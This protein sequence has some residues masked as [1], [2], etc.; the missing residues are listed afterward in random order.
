MNVNMSTSVT[1][2]SAAGQAATGEAVGLSVLKKAMEIESQ[3]AMMLINS[4][5]QPDKSAASL[6]SHLGQNVNTTA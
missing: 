3:S 4:V 1:L 6:P 5:A 2:A